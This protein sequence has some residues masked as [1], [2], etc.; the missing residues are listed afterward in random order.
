MPP[1]VNPNQPDST[2][3]SQ[4]L[5]TTSMPPASPDQLQAPAA[6]PVQAAPAMVPSAQPA[7]PPVTATSPNKH[8]MAFGARLLGA[9][10]GDPAPTY[11]YDSNG[12]LIT[13]P[14]APLTSG[15]KVQRILGHALTGL[16]APVDRDQKSGAAKALSGIGAGAEAVHE[17]AMKQDVL[18]RAQAKEN[19]EQE[20]QTQLRHMEIGKQNALTASIYFENLK[21]ANDLDPHFSSNQ[22]LFDAAKAS[23][24]LGAH[25]TEM[26]DS[27][28]E[29]A[30]KSDPMFTQTHILKPLGRAPALD[31]QGNPVLDANGQPTTY[32][33][34]GVIDGTKD[35]KIAITPQ[36]A[37]DFK[38]YGPMARIAGLENLKAG[39][40][41]DLQSLIPAMNKV[42]EQRKLV[43]DGWQKADLG[44]STDDKGKET[45][46]LINRA[47]PPGDPDS[48]RSL[49]VKPLALK[50]EEDKSALDKAQEAADYGKAREALANAAMISGNLPGNQAAIPAYMDAISKLPSSSQAILRNVP[51]GVQ[52]S[53]LKVANGDADLNKTFPTRVTKGSGQLDAQH[54]ENLVSL[55]NP[56]NPATGSTGWTEGMFKEKQGVI[57]KLSK[58]PSIASFNQFLVH[59]DDTRQ[60]SEKL[61]RTGSPAVNAAVNEIR[62]KY[63]G[64]PGV[65]ALMADI[66]AARSEWQTFIKSGHAS[67]IADT[68]ASRTIMSDASTPAQIM[69][70][71]RE[72]GKQAAG[73]LDQIDAQYRRS[74][75]GHYPGLV[76]TTGRQAAINLG[77]GDAIAQYPGEST[78]GG[79]SLS[80]VPNSSQSGPN[81]PPAASNEVWVDGKLVGHTVGNK[82][83]PLGQQ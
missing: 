21:R 12:K 6:A 23:P 80:G 30:E 22:A 70:A 41:Y 27:Q 68:E 44:W 5:P 34:I 13:T 15:Q 48:V 8:L 37:D 16:A 17:Q 77:L 78:F 42:E 4:Q 55:L 7:A 39:D 83:V 33:R 32:M 43:L 3:D 10:A 35:G 26:T 66:M 73:R 65:P 46:V 14:A 69:D 79:A 47:L 54:A 31:E 64:Q 75:G 74:Y 62:T 63:M 25:A 53:L 58:D 18:K 24:E 61:R 81:A 51:P 45:P 29:Q 76:S 2:A 56:P 59:A 11:S 40:E 9:I 72:M 82:Y 49:T 71:L 28:L 60:S 38:K 36:M 52:M 57:D 50:Q 1:E 19:F 20:Q 67:D